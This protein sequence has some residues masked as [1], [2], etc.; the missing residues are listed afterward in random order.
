MPNTTSTPARALN[1]AGRVFDLSRPRVMGILNITPDSFSDGGVLFDAGQPALDRILRKAETMVADGVDIFDIG[2]ESTRPGATAV[3]SAEELDRVIPVVERL[4]RTFDIPISV[5][6]STP[7][8][9]LEAAGRGAGLINDVRALTRPGAIRAVAA[10]GLPVCLMHFRGEPADMQRDPQYVDVVGEVV[11]FL[12]QRVEA[13][14]KLGIA[15]RN[16]VLDPGFGFGKNAEH[17]LT[18]LNRLEQLQALGFPLLVGLSRKSLI[19][20]VLGRPLEQRLAGS[21]ALAAIATMRG[22]AIIRVHDVRETVDVVRLCA[23]VR[24]ECVPP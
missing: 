6:T 9:I 12:H 3:S 21:L 22:A 14:T 11:D 13:C 24:A 15:R 2:G 19:G 4:A 10:T 18:L 1:C 17:N 5:D 20:K 8:V 23:A 16:I 7:V